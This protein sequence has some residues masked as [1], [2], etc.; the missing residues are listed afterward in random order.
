MSLVE[1]TIII[2]H[3]PSANCDNGSNRMGQIMNQRKTSFEH[4]SANGQVNG[5]KI[6]HGSSIPPQPVREEIRYKSASLLLS[7][8]VF[9]DANGNHKSVEVI[10]KRFPSGNVDSIDNQLSPT[11]M[12]G[13]DTVVDQEGVM[14]IAIL[15][16][17]IL[18]DC[19][20]LVKKYRPSL[21]SYVLEFPARIV[22]NSRS[23]SAS[24]NSICSNGSNVQHDNSTIDQIE[25]AEA[26]DAAVRDVE[27]NTGYRSTQVKYVSPETAMDPELCDNKLKIVSMVIDGDDPIRNNF[28]SNLMT[29]CSSTN[30]LSSNDDHSNGTNSNGHVCSN[31][32]LDDVEVIPV[33]INGLLDRLNEYSRRNIIID[34]RVYSFAIGLKKGE[35]LAAAALKAEE[36]EMTI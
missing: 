9:S 20:V 18:C 34:S 7:E 23:R 27:Y 21:R 33:P 14:S 6:S 28:F 13:H 5:R 32:C 12:T 26:G 24:G 29:D 10:H 30:S 17:H 15:K 35:K 36:M 4:L 22:E 3:V 8:C 2:D 31:Q 25:K 16:R 19:L 11:S 1:P